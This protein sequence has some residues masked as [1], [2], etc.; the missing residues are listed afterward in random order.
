M[1]KG[2]YQD[3]LTPEC[4]LNIEGCARDGLTEKQIAHNI[5]ISEEPVE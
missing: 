5:G 3:W 4:L 1:D 2:K